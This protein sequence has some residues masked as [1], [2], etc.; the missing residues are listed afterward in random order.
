M[1]AFG[2]VLAIAVIQEE[3]G[4]SASQLFALSLPDPTF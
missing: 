2:R 1:V 3:Q 4:Q